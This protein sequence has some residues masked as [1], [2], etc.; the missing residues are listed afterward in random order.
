MDPRV[1]SIFEPQTLHKYVYVSN[2]PQ[3]KIDPTGEQ[4]FSVAGLL[5]VVAVAAIIGGISGYIQGGS[6]LAVQRALSFAVF[7]AA[8]YTLGA[9]AI[10]YF[11]ETAVVTAGTAATAGSGATLTVSLRILQ[12]AMSANSEIVRRWYEALKA[13]TV[14]DDP[15][16]LARGWRTITRV[17]Q[18]VRDEMGPLGSK[19]RILLYNARVELIMRSQHPEEWKAIQEWLE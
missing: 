1:G 8:A 3:D 11:A 6:R 15:D 4:E 19:L 13:K 9:F 14:P 7:A 18:Q 17:Q 10:A 5:T 16:L 12:Q 2:D